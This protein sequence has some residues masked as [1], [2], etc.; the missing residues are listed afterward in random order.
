[1]ISDNKI[2]SSVLFGTTPEGEKVHLYTLRNRHGVEVCIMNYGGIVQSIKTPDRHGKFDDI[3]LGFDTFDG[4][5][6]G[7]PYFGALVGRYGNRIA[8]G[9]FTLDG[10]VCTLAKNNGPNSLHGGLKGFDKAV[11]EGRAGV[12]NLGEFLELNYLSK[13]GEEGF[14]GNLQVKAVYS[15]TD[16]NTLQ[17]EYTAKTDKTT[18]VNLTQ[19][20]Y[21][22]LA[23]QGDVLGHEISINASKFTPVDD[24]LIPTGELRDVAGTPFDFLKPG[25]IGKRIAE[26]DAQLKLGRGYDHN[27]VLT[28]QGPGL[29]LAAR[30]SEPVTGRIL[31]VWTTEPATQFYSGNFLD[32]SLTGKKGRVYQARNGFCL[33]PQ[34]YPDS[35]N[36][37]AFP[38][39]VLQPGAVY[40]N[41][42]ICKF[43]AK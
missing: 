29:S 17:L 27:F 36:H 32:G 23:C 34:H 11:W 19:H 4:Y 43:F 13:D 6:K 3:V 33:E 2:P 12:G 21:Y 31:E 24:G 37:P 9:K 14:P 39:T 42:I 10:H 35:P 20:S 26:N 38:S 41:I 7:H 5:L 30:V 8:G 25:L 1:M 16:D 18:V 22:N 28:N 40:H 15:L